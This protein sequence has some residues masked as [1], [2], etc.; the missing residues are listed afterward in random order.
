[1]KLNPP[2]KI[3]LPGHLSE[4]LEN[5]RR[6]WEDV[7]IR[8][9]LVPLPEENGPDH[10]YARTGTN[11]ISYCK[12]NPIIFKQIILEPALKMTGTKVH[13]EYSRLPEN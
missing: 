4:Y 1:V 3:K 10:I 8:E 13:R 12:F 7:L 6:T 2:Q 5:K 11:T 9:I